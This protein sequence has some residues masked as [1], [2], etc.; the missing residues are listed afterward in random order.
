MS[1]RR[2]G[3]WAKNEAAANGETNCPDTIAADTCDCT[4]EEP[5]AKP[6]KRAPPSSPEADPTTETAPVEGHGPEVI[7]Q[8]L[9][10]AVSFGAQRLLSPLEVNFSQSH[11][12]PE[13]QDGSS[14]EEGIRGLVMEYCAPADVGSVLDQFGV[15]TSGPGWWLIQSPFPEIEVIQWQIK[16]RN[17]DGSLKLDERGAELYGPLDWFSLDNRRLYCL[18][19]AAA[20][21][22]PSDVKCVV[23]VTRQQDY[24]Y[25]ET[26]KFRT[27]DM[28]RSIGIG[29]R[30]AVD[31]PRWS[32]RKEVGAPEEPLPEGIPMH[33]PKPQRRRFTG[34]GGRG[35]GGRRAEEDDEN[36]WGVGRTIMLSV[37]IYICV[38]M[39]VHIVWKLMTMPPEKVGAAV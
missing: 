38:R 11:I 27:P 23:T 34:R 26:R 29:H 39:L 35:Q 4:G 25:R 14:I 18:Q 36:E 21:K 32:W 5:V 10:G 9:N 31:M 15:P 30:E 37:P 13:F 16:M 28:G 24:N 33:S 6:A 7:L 17:E 8:L 20:S 2:R 3:R 22:W 19:R 12:R 1:V